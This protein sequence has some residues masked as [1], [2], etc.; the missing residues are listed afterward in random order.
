VGVRLGLWWADIYSADDMRVAMKRVRPS[1]RALSSSFHAGNASVQAVALLGRPRVT[2]P[3]SLTAAV[4]YSGGLQSLLFSLTRTPRPT[5]AADF[6]THFVSRRRRL[7]GGWGLVAAGDAG[8]GK[9][10]GVL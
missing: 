7:S 9:H 5:L 10:A 1:H 2:H 6:D 8:E 4:T 3:P